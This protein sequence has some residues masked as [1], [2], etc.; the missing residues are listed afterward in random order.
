[1]EIARLVRALGEAPPVVVAFEADAGG[2]EPVSRPIA[3]E[4]PDI[5]TGLVPRHS[6]T[7]ARAATGTR[8]WPGPPLPTD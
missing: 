5:L 4:R 7:G 3:A 2:R 6:R 8:D 1:M